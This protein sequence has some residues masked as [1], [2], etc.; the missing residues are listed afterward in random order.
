MFLGNVFL[1]SLLRLAPP[2]PTWPAPSAAC[3]EGVDCLLDD[4]DG[5][6]LSTPV[7]SICNRDV[8][9]GDIRCFLCDVPS[10]M[11]SA[12]G[13]VVLAPLVWA[14]AEAAGSRGAGAASPAVSV[15][16]IAVVWL[17]V[18]TIAV[19]KERR[20]RTSRKDKRPS[21]YLAVTVR[22]QILLSEEKHKRRPGGA[23][24]VTDCVVLLVPKT[25]R[26]SQDVSRSRRASQK[27]LSLG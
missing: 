18:V 4:G 19:R 10:S 23:E 9:G 11:S 26:L 5:A 14:V 15:V 7:L 17:M 3:T 21:T 16:D 2:T 24:Q 8:V 20:A 25:T 12:A 22:Y 13:R 27:T 1:S 6:S